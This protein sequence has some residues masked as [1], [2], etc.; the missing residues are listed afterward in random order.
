MAFRLVPLRLI[1]RC[2]LESIH[3]A[4]PAPFLTDACTLWLMAP[5]HTLECTVCAEVPASLYWSRGER[6]ETPG[7]QRASFAFPTGSRSNEREPTALLIGRLPGRRGANHSGKLLTIILNSLYYR[8]NCESSC[9]GVTV[10]ISRSAVQQWTS[11]PVNAWP[12]R[13]WQVCWGSRGL[14]EG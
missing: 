9:K 6:H 13:N 12:W 3:S 8:P 14:K 1:G 5:Q 7:R 4:V 2:K 11:A 10:M